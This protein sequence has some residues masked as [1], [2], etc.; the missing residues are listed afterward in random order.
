VRIPQSRFQFQFRV[1]LL[2]V[3]GLAFAVFLSSC[4]R[5]KAS[6]TKRYPFT[7]RVISIDSQTKSAVI[8]GDAVPGFMDPMAMPYK[9]KPEDTLSQLA[10]G[11]SIA[12]EVVV[13]QP[14]GKAASDDAVPEYWLEKVKVT[15]HSKPPSTSD[16]TPH[17]PATGEDVPDFRL[18]NQ[19]GRQISLADYRGKT[20]Y[21]TFVYTRCPFP[22]YCPRISGKFAEIYKRTAADSA[23]S[24]RTHL[25]SIS[26]DPEQDTP[27]ILR[28]Y[29]FSVAHTHEAAL[30]NRW[31]FAAPTLAE[32]PQ[33]ANFFG[34]TYK[35]EKGVIT[36]NLSTTVIGPDGKIVAWYHGA[37]WETS[38]LMKDAASPLAQR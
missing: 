28:D 33:I 8:D 36:H 35:P 3:V 32:L 31:E 18:T 10:P 9:I 19:S 6:S 23:L 26:F 1:L 25:L 37:E 34:L 15:A 22:D 2:A 13:V 21:L 12:A 24:K 27:K 17:V 16:A 38:D 4:H 29:G 7:G 20:L 14:E 11:D 30:F 5:P